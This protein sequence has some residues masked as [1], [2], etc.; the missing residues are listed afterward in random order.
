MRAAIFHEPHRVEA[1]DRPDASL[2]EPTDAL[3]RVALACVCGTDLW[4]YRGDSPFPPGPIGHEFIGVV[5]DVGRRSPADQQ[6]RPRHRIVHVL[7]QHVPA[8]PPRDHV[9]V[10]KRRHLSGQRRRRAG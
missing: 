1:G 5:E 4:F 2:R 6:G 7:R 3:V 8:L 10:H 9:G